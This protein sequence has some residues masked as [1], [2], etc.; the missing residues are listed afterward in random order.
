M[1]DT[2]SHIY[3][4]EF[5]SDRKEIISRAKQ[6]GVKK[7]LMPNIDSGSIE[8]ML[9]TEQENSE[10][11]FA[12]MGLHPTS[13]NEEFEKEL[14]IVSDW[15]KKRKFIALGEIGIDL[16]WDKTFKEQQIKV[17]EEQVRM[18]KKYS[19][20]VVVHSRDAFPEVF[21]VIDR[22]WDEN[23][24]GVF[25]SFTGTEDELF[26]ILEYETFY[27]G[28]NGVLTFKNT[29]LRE[30]IKN[31]SPEKILLETDAP[32]LTPVPFRGKRNEPSYVKYVCNVLADV[33]GISADRANDI[34]SENAKAL[35]FNQK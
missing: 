31:T 11:C 8:R 13:V 23:L 17:F 10:Y 19:V 29:N 24:K 6:V 14:D 30:V 15:F 34:T 20:P 3:L 1:I 35:F 32:Y 26:H 33:F 7:I 4:E 12:M 18:A 9:K 22:L 27:L 16:Y 28:L 25:H 5:D 21:S 2:H